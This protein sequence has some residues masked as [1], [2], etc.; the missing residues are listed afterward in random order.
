MKS[1]LD[2]AAAPT[3]TPNQQRH[4]A[5]PEC[6]AEMAN[7]SQLDSHVAGHYLSASTEYG[8]QSCLKLFSKPDELQKHLMDVHAY[9]LYRCAL[10]KQMFDSKVRLFI[11]VSIFDKIIFLFIE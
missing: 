9:H 7:E 5:C 10:C 8:C 3:P 6:G 4:F 1:H 2:A 11:R